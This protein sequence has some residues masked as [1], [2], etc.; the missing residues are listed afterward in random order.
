MT[1]ISPAGPIALGTQAHDTSTLTGAFNPTG[2]VTYSLY[3]DNHCGTLVADLTPSSNTVTSSTMP[4]SKPFTFNTAGTF[5]FV[6]TYSGD[7]NNTGPVNSGCTAEPLTVGP[8]APAVVTVISPAGP[9]AL[10]T[11]AHDTSTL[12]G[13][14]NPTGTVTYSLYSDNHCGTLVADLT[15]KPEHGHV[16]D[17]ARLEALLPSTPLAR[18]TSSRPTVATATT[19]TP[20]SSTAAAPPNRSPSDR[21]QPAVV[22]VISPAGPIALGTQARTP[23]R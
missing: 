16:L 10:G 18:S 3:S 1:V 8:K 23:G 19:T 13:A 21:R 4:D 5:Y 22:T 7:S 20:A 17:D 14:F 6:A 12:T 2:T 9:I 15:P 11:Q